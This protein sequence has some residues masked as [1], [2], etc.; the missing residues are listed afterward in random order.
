MGFHFPSPG[1]L[2]NPGLEPVSPALAGG[3][4]TTAPPWKRSREK[5]PTLKGVAVRMDHSATSPP[6]VYMVYGSSQSTGLPEQ[7]VRRF[8]VQ[9]RPP[10][11][12]R[13]LPS[14]LVGPFPVRVRPPLQLKLLHSFLLYL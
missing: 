13:L 7:G 14:F 3:F 1:D 2:L 4:F 12:L 10:L 11:Q 5:I 8:P 6:C 9:V